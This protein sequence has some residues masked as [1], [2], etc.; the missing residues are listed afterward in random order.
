[1]RPLEKLSDAALILLLRQG[2][3]KAFDELYHRYVPRLMTFARTYI[4]DE[5]EAEEAVQE[6]F[7]K[8][9]EKRKG[10]DESKNFKSYL[11]QSVKNRLLNL[12]RDRKANCVLEDI[13]A[14]QYSREDD[15]LDNLTYKELERTA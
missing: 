3:I 5:Q 6:I 4:W 7:I 1:M 8:V 10:L 11:F 15:L 12:I 14:E 13:P 2:E 9:W